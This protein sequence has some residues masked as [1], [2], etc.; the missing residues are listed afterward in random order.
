MLFFVYL[1][2]AASL[3][4]DAFYVIGNGFQLAA[5][6]ALFA[7]AAT[8]DGERRAQTISTWRASPTPANRAALFIGRSLP[9]I[10]NAVVVSAIAFVASALLLHV[11][12]AAGSYPSLALLT[13]VTAISCTGFGL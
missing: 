13:L 4:S 5:L 2:R 10:A 8:I 1:G 12:I 7:M 9:V 11:H 6:P 3:E